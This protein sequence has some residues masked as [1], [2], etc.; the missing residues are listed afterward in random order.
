MTLLSRTIFNP[1]HDHA[2]STNPRKLV[3][4]TARYQNSSLGV[5]A[6]TWIPERGPR[7]SVAPQSPTKSVACSPAV[8][9]QSPETSPC[10]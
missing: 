1:D 7:Y 6:S 3:K 8:K 4:L 9:T 10:E 5:R 2:T